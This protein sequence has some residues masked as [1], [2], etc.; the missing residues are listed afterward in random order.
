MQKFNIQLSEQSLI[1]SIEIKVYRVNESNIDQILIGGVYL[2]IMLK[3][4]PK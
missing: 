2:E 1:S 3:Y 4:N